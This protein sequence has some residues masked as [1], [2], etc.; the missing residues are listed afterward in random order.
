MGGSRTTCCFSSLKVSFFLYCLPNT[1]RRNSWERTGVNKSEAK[2]PFRVLGSCFP[3]TAP[4]SLIGPPRS[5]TVNKK[6]RKNRLGNCYF[7]TKLNETMKWWMKNKNNNGKNVP[8]EISTCDHMV[9]WTSFNTGCHHHALIS[10]WCT[11]PRLKLDTVY[12]KTFFNCQIPAVRLDGGRREW[13]PW[14]RGHVGGI[15]EKPQILVRSPP[16][17]IPLLRAG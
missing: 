3:G 1:F 10:N 11:Q 17:H 2:R 5:L 15:M 14:L 7:Q 16:D 6:K 12:S 4:R 8:S 9:W 13:W